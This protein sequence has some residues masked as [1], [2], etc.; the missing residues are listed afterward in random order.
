VGDGVDRA[1]DIEA[2][3][4]AGSFNPDAG[5][6]PQRREKGTENKM[7]SIDKEYGAFPGL[8][9]IQQGRQCFF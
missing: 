2:L 1:E 3:S 8:G 4:T 9:F 5:E 7:C 6:A